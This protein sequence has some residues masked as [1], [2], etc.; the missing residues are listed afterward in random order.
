MKYI[1]ARFRLSLDINV[2]QRFE[3]IVFSNVEFRSWSNVIPNY[4]NSQ[5]TSEILSTFDIWIWISFLQ[6]FAPSC[7]GTQIH[8]FC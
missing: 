3:K 4:V 7:M 6:D 1:N 2:I 8:C 5:N